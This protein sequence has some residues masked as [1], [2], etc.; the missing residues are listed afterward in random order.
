MSSGAERVEAALGRVR[1]AGAR[2]RE[3]PL[4]ERV[5][6]TGAVLERL[7]DPGSKARQRLVREL[8]EATGFAP[9]TLARGLEI[10]LEPFTADA[11]RALAR[12]ELGSD[13]APRPFETISV[14]LAGAL[15]TPSLLQVLPP[16]LLGSGVV[17]KPAAHDPVTPAVI[18][19][20][21]ADLD[22]SLGE[23][24]ELV[25]FGRDD[26]ASATALCR[27][28]C[29]VVTGG[30]DAVASYAARISPGRRLVGAGH[31]FS[32]GI[33]GEDAAS[34]T[35]LEEAAAGLALDTALWD[36]LGCLSPVAVFV[37]GTERV[38][39]AVMEAFERAF[40]RLER[41][42]PRGRLPLAARAALSQARD[43]AELR[44]AAD[45]ST[46]VLAAP[47]FT[48]VAESETRLRGSPLHRFLRLHPAPD[49][50]AALEALRPAAGHLAGV[51][52]AGLGDPS[53]MGRLRALGASRVAPAGRLQAP[54]LSWPRENRPVLRPL[55]P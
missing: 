16:L 40:A 36:Q 52:V 39:D 6:W 55:L 53:L 22:P 10:A 13:A 7:R 14:V 33:L 48:L 21:L 44:S 38:P 45:G 8:P 54:P 17:V 5:E 1:L 3:R 34:A 26:E 30:D 11:W 47:A 12:D 18:R 24:L 9:P 19:D 25:A 4:R 42:L 37:L 29:V 43:E 15:P 27:A 35:A 41:E 28:D 31:R 2:L 46:R 20:E 49:A 51:A 32:V 23:A 50:E